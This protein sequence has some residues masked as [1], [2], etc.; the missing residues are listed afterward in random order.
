MLGG[1]TLRRSV[2][3][4][5]FAALAVVALFAPGARSPVLAASY[6]YPCSDYGNYR[7]FIY[8]GD[9][10]NDVP[11]I[12]DGVGHDYYGVIGDMTVNGPAT[13]TNTV[14]PVISAIL[15]A[16]LEKAPY[17][18]QLGIAVCY[19]STSEKCGPE[20]TG[21]PSDGQ[22]HFV[23]ICNDAS[24]GDPCLADGWVGGPPEIHDRY[25][26]RIEKSGSS[27]L[28]RLQNITEGWTSTKTIPRSSGF[29][30]GNLAWWAAETY[31][32]GSMLGAGQASASMIKM[33][34]MQYHRTAIS[35]WQVVTPG[36]QYHKYPAGWTW[37]S[38]WQQSVYDQNYVDDAQNIWTVQH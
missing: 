28:Y 21:I 37:P 35:G 4:L 19:G 12:P 9:G 26:F 27:W 7:T 32:R 30:F 34:W 20:T 23:Y 38:Y 1:A 18:V 31:D 25:R 33:Y 16:N 3:V 2:G 22:L 6:T 5:S 10:L 29:D 24:G 13:C 11:G 15:P 8:R 14:G 17:I 36:V